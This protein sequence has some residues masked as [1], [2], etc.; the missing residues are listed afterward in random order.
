MEC[1]EIGNPKNP[2]G[3][4]QHISPLDIAA[5]NS[6]ILSMEKGGIGIRFEEVA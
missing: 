5:S 3:F 1:S 6:E 4:A 2:S